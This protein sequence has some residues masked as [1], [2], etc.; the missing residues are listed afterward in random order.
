VDADNGPALEARA[1]VK[2]RDV[3]FEI[4]PELA[5]VEGRRVPIGYEIEISGEAD[6]D[7]ADDVPGCERCDRA[8]AELRRVAE[9]A[10]A[11][12]ADIPSYDSSWHSAPKDGPRRRIVLTIRLTRFDGD[13]ESENEIEHARLASIEKR[14]TELGVRRGR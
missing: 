7:K 8:F 1:I 14:L 5:L 10:G 9:L 2:E 12:P 11:R 13:E 3:R 4:W 6:C